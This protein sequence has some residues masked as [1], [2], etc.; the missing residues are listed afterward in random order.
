[1][2]ESTARTPYSESIAATLF[3]TVSIALIVGSLL[4]VATV[5][6]YRTQ[7]SAAVYWFSLVTAVFWFSFGGHWVELLHLNVIR[8]KLSRSRTTEVVVRLAVWSLGGLILFAGM[9]TTLTAFGN[10]LLSVFPWWLGGF[11]F[12]FVELI[13]H[14]IS[15]AFGRANF[16][17]G[18]G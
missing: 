11:F 6:W 18:D 4:T 5:S 10:L 2:T 12:I 3:R 15:A 9:K 13:V 8:M 7:L 14:T 1:M 17:S 16:W